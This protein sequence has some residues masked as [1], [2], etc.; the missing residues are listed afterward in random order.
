MDNHDV[1]KNQAGPVQDSSANLPSLSNGHINGY[2][3]IK[4]KKQSSASAA[5]E[6]S[7]G[8]QEDTPQENSGFLN[9]GAV[10]NSSTSLGS[11]ILGSSHSLAPGSGLTD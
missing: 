1:T 3:S 10:P 2:S 6:V 9:A 5:L 8:K 4:S 7:G 11:K